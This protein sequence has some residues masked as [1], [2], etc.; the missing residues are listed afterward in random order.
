MPVHSDPDVIEAVARASARAAA[1]VH[2]KMKRGLSS[3]A[4]MA[5]TAPFVGLFGTIVGLADSFH[6]ETG[7]ISIHTS[8][9][10]SRDRSC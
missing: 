10:R 9:A 3:L 8:R 5:A 4:S 2:Q 1:G 7:P 6:V